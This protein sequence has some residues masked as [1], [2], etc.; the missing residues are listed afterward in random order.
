MLLIEGG[1]I[2]SP[3][4]ANVLLLDRALYFLVAAADDDNTD[5]SVL[6]SSRELALAS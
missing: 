1:R 6:D 5:N 3:P 2:D 4:T